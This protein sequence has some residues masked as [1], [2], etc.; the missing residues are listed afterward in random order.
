MRN[1]TALWR[2][3]TNLIIMSVMIFAISTTGCGGNQSVIKKGKW[4]KAGLKKKIM[5]LPL[6]NQSGIEKDFSTEMSGKLLNLLKIAPSFISHDG[7]K[8]VSLSNDLRSPEF[9]IVIPPELVKKA[10]DLGMN[11][12]VTGV[13]NPL[14]KSVRKS[15]IWPLRNLKNVYEISMIINV[16]DTTTGTLLFTNLIKDEVIFPVEEE[17]EKSENEIHQ[18]L[19]RAMSGIL[20][21]LADGAIKKLETASWSGKIISLENNNAKIRGGTDVG[22][23]PGQLFEV[24]A[25][26]ES[27]RSKDGR[28]FTIFGKKVGLIKVSSVA[29]NHCLAVP[30]GDTALAKGQIVYFKP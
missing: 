24:F 25:R 16:V 5:I 29:E 1:Q 15:G 20:E 22:L 28:V 2:Q 17:T 19:K 14:E 12:L 18:E 26:G 4:E 27:I 10:E 23:R 11:A 9:G 30:V 21:D 6:V 7:S 13:L 8:Y 3:K